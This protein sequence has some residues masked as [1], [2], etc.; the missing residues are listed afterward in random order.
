MARDMSVKQGEDQRSSVG[1]GEDCLVTV[2][3]LTEQRVTYSTVTALVHQ[4]QLA[5]HQAGNTL[6]EGIVK[7]FS[8]QIFLYQIFC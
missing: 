4:P 1:P 8:Y 6:A 5:R 7:I 3:V 2:G